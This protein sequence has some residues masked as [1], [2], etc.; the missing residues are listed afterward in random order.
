MNA[1]VSVAIA[2]TSVFLLS[3]IY[4]I[5]LSPIEVRA[6]GQAAPDRGGRPVPTK[7]LLELARSVLLGGSSRAWPEPP[8][9]TASA[10]PCCCA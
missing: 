7:A 10:P 4:C 2:G 1:T 6:L 3:S 5:T 9:Y 8:T